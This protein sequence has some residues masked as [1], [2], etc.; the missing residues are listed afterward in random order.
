MQ[1][2]RRAHK[3]RGWYAPH[4]IS[5]AS[6]PSGRRSGWAVRRFDSLVLCFTQRALHR[7]HSHVV[8]LETSVRCAQV[9]Q[10]L[11][12]IE[13]MAMKSE[14]VWGNK[15]AAALAPAAAEAVVRARL[16][17]ACVVTVDWAVETSPLRCTTH[18]CSVIFPSCIQLA[19]RARRRSHADCFDCFASRPHAMHANACLV[20][21]TA[22]TPS[23]IVYQSSILFILHL[24]KCTVPK[25]RYNCSLLVCLSV[26]FIARASKK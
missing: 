8:Y 24:Y 18:V 19:R 17:F 6:C 4:D 14:A 2:T 13:Y 21:S 10:V 22:H 3:E 1:R 9:H 11:D 5:L 7:L 20:A 26:Y 15:D 25:V 12:S 23:Y 16:Y